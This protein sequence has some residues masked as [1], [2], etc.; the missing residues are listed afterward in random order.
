MQDNEI[1]KEIDLLS[2]ASDFKSQREYVYLLNLLDFLETLAFYAN[3]HYVGAIELGISIYFFYTI[4][5]P[6][7]EDR[8]G[9]YG[10]KDF[11]KEFEKL[12]K[13]CN[14]HSNKK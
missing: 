9:K 13:N 14:P 10:Q 5:T 8:K 11:Y 2:R 7:I 3:N 4:F 12:A 6:R 1:G